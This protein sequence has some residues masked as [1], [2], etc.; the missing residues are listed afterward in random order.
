[1]MDRF[2]AMN[3]LRLVVDKGSFTAAAKAARLPLPTVSRKIGELEAHLGTRLLARSTRRLAVTDAGLAYLDA[4]RRILD[5][6]DEAERTAAGEY[7]TPRGDLVVTAPILFG[8]LHILPILTDFLA[9][10]PEI[11]VRFLLSD[12]NLHLIDD[13]VDLGIRIGRMPDSPMLATRVGA[14]RTV[15]CGAPQLI[16]AHGTPQ[17]PADLAVYPTVS[18]NL[19]LQAAATS[20]VFRDAASHVRIEVPI[21][22]RL[23]AT[24]AEVAVAAAMRGTGLTRVY[25]YQAAAALQAGALQILLPDC[26]AEP[27][28]VQVIHAGRDKLPLKTRVFLDFTAGRLRSELGVL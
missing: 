1:M 28:P 12:R 2:E 7:L 16:A 21:A 18:F 4:A 13:H 14:M 10:Y 23:S 8:R 6:V 19:D 11:D 22:P 17:R 27:D 5:D 24:T 26:E 9:A 25:H 20:W 15:L 3:L